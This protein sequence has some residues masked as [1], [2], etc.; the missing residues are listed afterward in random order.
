MSLILVV[1][2]EKL[3]RE[4]I[5]SALESWGGESFRVE[6]VANGKNALAR[7]CDEEADQVDLVV[8]DIRM[9]IMGGLELLRELAARDLRIPSIVLSAHADFRYAQEAIHLGVAEYVLKPIDPALLVEAVEKGL[10]SRSPMREGSPE[11]VAA[12]AG[13]EILER[14]QAIWNPSIRGAV[15]YLFEN[16]RRDIGV[17][18]LANIVHLNESYFCTL[19]KSE[20]GSTFSDFVMRMRLRKA[21]ELLLTTDERIYEIAEKI[22]YT[23]ARYFAK[24]FRDTVGMTPRE[25]RAR[26]RG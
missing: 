6:T 8:T 25:Y 21:K 3:T 5:R 17:R 26:Y 7:L 24:V 1:E 16:Y 9:P 13:D 20:T 18:E 10:A 11:L 12:L 19:F 14:A 22:G 23:T 15:E 2:D 4:G